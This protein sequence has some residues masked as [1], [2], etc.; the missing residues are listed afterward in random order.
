MP[1]GSTPARRQETPMA[2]R[3]M[4]KVELA[5]RRIVDDKLVVYLV[6]GLIGL[7]LIAFMVVPVFNIL[8]LS[9]SG[10]RA[11]SHEFLGGF[12]FDNYLNYFSKPAIVQSLFNSLWVSL[13]STLFTT[14]LAFF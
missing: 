2:A 1:S 3:E 11:E 13:W 6:G 8:R 14:V 9:V 4:Q 5:Q 7:F 10:Y 12:T